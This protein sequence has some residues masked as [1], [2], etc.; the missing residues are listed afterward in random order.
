MCISLSSALSCNVDFQNVSGLNDEFYLLFDSTFVK[1]INL[2]QSGRIISL[3]TFGFQ[4]LHL[5]YILSD[6]HL[7]ETCRSRVFIFQ[8]HLR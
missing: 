5:C 7:A 1:M 4:A 8:S 3:I 6:V 2:E